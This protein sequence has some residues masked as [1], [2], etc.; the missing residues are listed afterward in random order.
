LLLEILQRNLVPYLKSDNRN[1][2]WKIL[3][4]VKNSDVVEARQ[5]ALEIIDIFAEWGDYEWG[6]FLDDIE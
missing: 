6:V 3:E 5:Q 2:I 1:H 4:Q